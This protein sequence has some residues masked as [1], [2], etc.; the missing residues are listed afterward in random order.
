MSYQ[1]CGRETGL[2]MENLLAAGQKGVRATLRDSGLL[3][4]RV[5]LPR[6][7]GGGAAKTHLAKLDMVQRKAERIIS[8][9]HPQQPSTLQNL[10]HRWDVAGLTILYKVQQQTMVH[11]QQLHQ[12]L[13]QAEV[14]MRGAA[15]TPSALI[16]PCSHTTHHPRQFVQRLSS[17]EQVSG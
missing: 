8:E 4:T 1:N 2:S 6:L 12:P 16:I 13:H 9:D 7:G 5:F 3:L 15:R 10:Q 17:G 14:R 11:L